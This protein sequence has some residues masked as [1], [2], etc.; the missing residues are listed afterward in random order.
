MP[1]DVAIPMHNRCSMRSTTS[2]LLNNR[3]A[4]NDC[5]VNAE[6]FRH[7]CQNSVQ[8]TLRLTRSWLKLQVQVRFNKTR[9]V[10]SHRGVATIV[11]V[12]PLF[13]F[14]SRNTGRRDTSRGNQSDLLPL[15][16]AGYRLAR[17]DLPMASGAPTGLIR[18]SGGTGNGRAPCLFGR[19][20]PFWW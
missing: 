17:P 9:V 13:A 16:A 15:G 14:R 12:P 7:K 6:T 10:G 20:T 1:C 5:S 2:M 11:T 18:G 3:K 8:S 4:R 19:E